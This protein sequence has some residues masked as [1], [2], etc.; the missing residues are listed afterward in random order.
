VVRSGWEGL[1]DRLQP[2]AHAALELDQQDP[3]P[4]ADD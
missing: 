4:L 1:E 3:P 2:L